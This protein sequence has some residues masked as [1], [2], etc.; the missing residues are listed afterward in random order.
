MFSYT[1]LEKN[2]LPLTLPNPR[3]LAARRM[4]I[5][6]HQWNNSVA[7]CTARNARY[8]GAHL[9]FC[10]LPLNLRGVVSL[11]TAWPATPMAL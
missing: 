3:G 2:L 9:S 10:Q 4:A 1:N 8:P 7:A 11:F 5:V 6:N